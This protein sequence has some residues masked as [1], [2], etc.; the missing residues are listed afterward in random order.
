VSCPASACLFEDGSARFGAG[1]V[2]AAVGDVAGGE[3]DRKRVNNEDVF[4]VATDVGR[5]GVI[6]GAG[7][8]FEAVSNVAGK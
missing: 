1:A 6:S 8:G 5:E 3:V 4:V 7:M 2:V